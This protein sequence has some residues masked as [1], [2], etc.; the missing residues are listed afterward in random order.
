MCRCAYTPNTWYTPNTHTQKTNEIRQ[1][2]DAIAKQIPQLEACLKRSLMAVDQDTLDRE[3][4]QASELEGRLRVLT[5][6]VPAL[7][8]QLKACSS[9]LMA[10]MQHSRLS[11]QFMVLVKQF[12]HVQAGHR[13]QIKQDLRRQYLIVNPEASEQ[14]L[15]N[16][17]SDQQVLFRF[18][19]LIQSTNHIQITHKDDVFTVKQGSRTEDINGME[20]TAGRLEEY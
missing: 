3:T 2:M 12:E 18:S 17:G 9:G 14:E 10:R 6:E 1:R 19:S 13:E 15:V 20:G 16:L 8:N 4:R 11:K 7:L 5:N